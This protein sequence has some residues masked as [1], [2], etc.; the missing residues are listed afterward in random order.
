[1]GDQRRPSLVDV[2]TAFDPKRQ[3]SPHAARQ[4]GPTTPAIFVDRDDP[5]VKQFQKLPVHDKRLEVEPV[6]EPTLFAR[7]VTALEA[8]PATHDLIL[9]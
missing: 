2:S 9:T 7:H 8:D 4:A 1:M 3:L 6:G 5:V